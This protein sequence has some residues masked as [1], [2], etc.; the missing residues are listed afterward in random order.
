[1][2]KAVLSKALCHILRGPGI[3]KR[4]KWDPLPP[5]TQILNL[6]EVPERDTLKVKGDQWHL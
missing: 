3:K 4:Y 5:R 6:R 2:N 1:M